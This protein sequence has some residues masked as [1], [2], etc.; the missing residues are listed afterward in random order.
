MQDTTE[1]SA[2]PG[3]PPKSLAQKRLAQCERPPRSRSVVQRQ[4]FSRPTFLGGLG[5][6]YRKKRCIRYLGR[7]LPFLT[8]KERDL[9]SALRAYSR[10]EVTLAKAPTCHKRAI[11]QAFQHIPLGD[12]ALFFS[13]SVFRG[14]I[15]SRRATTASRRSDRQ[16]AERSIKLT[17]PIPRGLGR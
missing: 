7:C 8:K 9:G 15:V 6:S 13:S 11:Y 10:T 14:V 12:P 2:P 16:F 17:A 4:L 5:P 3:T 1:L